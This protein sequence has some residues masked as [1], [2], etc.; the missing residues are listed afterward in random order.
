MCSA[1][2]LPY[3]FDNLIP[4]TPKLKSAFTE[5]NHIEIYTKAAHTPFFE[6]ISSISLGGKYFSRLLFFDLIVND[7]FIESFGDGRKKTIPWEQK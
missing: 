7:I 1:S 5:S 4:I 6:T 2:V 3:I